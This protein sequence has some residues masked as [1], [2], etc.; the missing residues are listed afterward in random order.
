MSVGLSTNAFKMGHHHIVS[1]TFSMVM[2]V[3]L[4]RKVHTSRSPPEMPK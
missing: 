2:T 3:V 1:L 4:F